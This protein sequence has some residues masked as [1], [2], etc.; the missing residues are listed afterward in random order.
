[1]ESVDNFDYGIIFECFDFIRPPFC[2]LLFAEDRNGNSN[3]N[4]EKTK[5][6]DELL[7]SMSILCFNVNIITQRK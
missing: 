6:T 3:N 1:M 4:A 2:C 7:D 5:Y